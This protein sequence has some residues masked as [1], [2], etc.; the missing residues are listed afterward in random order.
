MVIA[1]EAAMAIAN[2]AA[3]AIGKEI[4]TYRTQRIQI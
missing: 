4:E 1:N 2:E 3:M